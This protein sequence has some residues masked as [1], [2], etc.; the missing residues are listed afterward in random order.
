MIRTP[1]LAH[2][3]PFL[4]TICASIGQLSR[5]VKVN[6]RHSAPANS[7]GQHL[8]RDHLGPQSRACQSERK[9]PKRRTWGRSVLEG[10]VGGGGG[11]DAKNSFARPNA[12]ITYFSSPPAN[13][14][15]AAIFICPSVITAVAPSW[16]TVGHLEFARSSE[17]EKKFAR[18]VSARRFLFI[19]RRCFRRM[20]QL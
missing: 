17:G 3:H 16:R 5:L 8:P 15:P 19:S 10:S 4:S 2:C 7:Q 13:C 12:S 18:V 1:S 11:K 14:R 9:Y 20:A 6:V